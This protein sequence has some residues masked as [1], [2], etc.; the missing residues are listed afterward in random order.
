MPM[1]IMSALVALVVVPIALWSDRRKKQRIA[2]ATQL[3]ATHGFVVDTST[4][5]PPPQRFDV[6]GTGSSKKVSFQFWGAGES[7]IF[8]EYQY[9]TGSGDNKTTHYRTLALIALPF[10]APHTK[11]G[12]EGFWSGIGR[13]V[14]MRDIEVE[15]TE[16]NDQYR[17]T[18]DDERFTVALLDQQMLGWLLS[19]QSGRGAVKF[20]LWDSWLVCVSDRLDMDQMFGFLDWAQR[21]RTHMPTV[22]SSLYPKQ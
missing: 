22:L 6:F 11:I 21:V 2:Y 5:G 10:T 14:G 3:A 4:K 7:D 19:S 20:E 15:S 17:V 18:S 1:L 13:F 8:F 9:T 12:P 16:F